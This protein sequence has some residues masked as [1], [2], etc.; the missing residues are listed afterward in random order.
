MAKF[1]CSC[2][3]VEEEHSRTGECQGEGCLCACY[4]EDEDEDEEEDD[5]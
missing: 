3:H 2:G 1:L 5:G 4:E